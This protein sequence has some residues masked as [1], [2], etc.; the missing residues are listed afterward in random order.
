MP[1]A[2]GRMGLLTPVLTLGRPIREPYSVRASF[3]VAFLGGPF[4]IILFSMV[5]SWRLERL[6]SDAPSY[7][8]LATVAACAMFVTTYWV[9]S[10]AMPTWAVPL[11]EGPS[12][13]NHLSRIVGLAVMAIV[14]LRHRR[15]LKAQAI[16]GNNFANPW[17]IGLGCVVVG[18][19]IGF[20]VA[21]LAR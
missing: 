7:V 17:A 19:A 14:Y 4:G 6:R 21:L 2:A 15:L 16:A 11:G 10:G 9:S 18:T 3:F 13:A 1:L 8:A 20:S 12:A 5:N